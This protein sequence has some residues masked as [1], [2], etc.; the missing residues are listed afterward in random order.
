MIKWTQQQID[1]QIET[2][3]GNKIIIEYI[4]YIKGNHKYKYICNMCN[5]TYISSFRDIKD[6]NSC[7]RCANVKNLEGLR[8]DKLQVLERT[9]VKGDSSYKYI[10]LCDC[11]NY[12]IKTGAS[13]LSKKHGHNCG[14]VKFKNTTLYNNLFI[15]YKRNAHHRHIN[16]ELSFDEFIE[17]IK[18]P[19]YYCGI[20]YSNISKKTNT[21]KHIHNIDLLYNGIDRLDSKQGYTN[22]NC[23]PACKQCNYAKSNY[24]IT[25][26]LNHINTIKNKQPYIKYEKQEMNS[27]FLFLF[28]V[29]KKSAIKRKYEFNLD[30]NTFYELTQ[31]TCA[32]CGS[33]PQ[34]IKIRNKYTFKYNGIDRINNT[35]GY[36]IDNVTSC[37]KI[38]NKMKRDLSVDEFYD[39][40]N[41]VGVYE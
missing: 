30:I 17:L 19:C 33:I 34:Q 38:C 40:I 35:I 10:C 11:G 25:Y 24:T 3:I 41:S 6:S 16:F 1:S 2:Q 5:N 4:G 36:V 29:Y 32:Y 37:C 13:L 14:C 8:F 18:R 26:F 22:D 28:D 20:T 31:N 39:W 15:D 12:T 27:A 21:I 9:L 7:K 23:V